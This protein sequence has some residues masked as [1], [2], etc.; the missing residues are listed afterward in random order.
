LR[1]DKAR[2]IEEEENEDEEETGGITLQQPL[3]IARRP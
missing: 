1:K 2:K 3:A